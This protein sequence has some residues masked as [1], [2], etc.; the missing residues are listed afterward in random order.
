M[1]MDF[2][3]SETQDF[4]SKASA[5]RLRHIILILNRISEVGFDQQ[6]VMQ[7]IVDSACE[8]TQAEGAVI[9]LQEADEMV[10]HSI[11]GPMTKGSLGLRLKF[12]S[13]L[14]GLCVRENKVLYSADSE[15]DDRVDLTA[16]KRI[17]V[18]S[19]IVL[20][21]TTQSAVVGVLKVMS[22]QTN[23]FS[24]DEEDSLKLLGSFLARFLNQAEIADVRNQHFET[25]ANSIPQ[26]AFMAEPDGFIHWYNSRWYD[27]TGSTPE[28][29]KGWG[30][31]T[32]HDPEH[33]D[34]VLE[35]WQASLKNKKQ[36]EITMPLKGRDGQFRWFLTRVLPITDNKGQV[37]SWFG[38][39]TDVHDHKLAADELVKAKE[40]AERANNLKTAFLANMSHE[41]RTPLGAMIGFAE[42]LGQPKLS[43]QDRAH[44]ISVLHRNGEQLGRLISDILDLSKAETGHVNF[45]YVKLSPLQLVEEVAALMTVV[46][47]QKNVSLTFVNELSL[48]T[49]IVT[50]PTRAKQVLINLV[51][52]AIKFTEKGYV[53]IRL[54][55]LE[56]NKKGCKFEVSDTGVGISEISIPR[57]FKMFN[58][59]D[60]SMTR[61]YGGTGLGLSLS[62]SLARAMGG[63]V[64]LVK[65]AIDKGSCFSFTI[66]SRDQ[67]LP[68]SGVQEQKQNHPIPKDLNLDHMRILVVEDSPDN[69]ELISNYLTRYGAQVEIAVNGLDGLIKAQ[70]KNYDVILMD[71]QMP[72]MDGYTAI[73]KLRS[74]GLNQP[75]IALTAHTLSDVRQ[76]CRD[77]G[78]TDFLPKPIDSKHLVETILQYARFSA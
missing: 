75:I 61:R 70:A 48:A 22:A 36:L 54:S 60:N 6:K 78:C 31:Q 12:Q 32:V 39:N 51:S 3:S 59:A 17:G 5:A 72:V 43:D 71:L 21:L 40:E 74:M 20:P 69:Q 63:D 18:K 8:L 13:S 49:E 57:L 1:L 23:F 19:M 76:K 4:L 65:T 37:M 24:K 56:N 52:N 46:A 62:R 42:L 16:V 50:D 33:L 45:D 27:Y 14:S 29:M 28:Q 38:T 15:N 10:Y 2:N 68:A 11:S 44:F 47:K 66:E 77:V 55:N 73:G 34:R 7:S 9:E 26:L 35:E 30:W 67:L 41:I 58:Q 53:E 64:E 25:L